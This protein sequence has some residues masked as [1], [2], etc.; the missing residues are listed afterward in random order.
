MLF[1]IPMLDVNHYITAGLMC[2]LPGHADGMEVKSWRT[3]DG[4][5]L[6]RTVCTVPVHRVLT[7]ILV[8]IDKART[9]PVIGDDPCNMPATKPTHVLYGLPSVPYVHT[10]GRA[11]KVSMR[12]SSVPHSIGRWLS[13]PSIYDV[14]CGTEP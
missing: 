9:V 13:S 3:E 7:T 6:P 12:R 8:E 4:T 5:V 14:G 11:F 2:R 1:R 10:Y